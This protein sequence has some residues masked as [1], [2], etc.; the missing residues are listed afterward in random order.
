MGIGVGVEIDEWKE[1]KYLEF[2][3]RSPRMPCDP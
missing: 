1:Y 2:V 3:D